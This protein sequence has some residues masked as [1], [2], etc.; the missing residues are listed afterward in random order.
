MVPDVCCE[1]EREKRGFEGDDSCGRPSL[2]VIVEV[3]V[4]GPWCDMSSVSG[5]SAVCSSV[6]MVEADQRDRETLY[7]GGSDFGR[8]RDLAG[9]VLRSIP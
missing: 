3:S 4:M 6:E 8:A 2:Y 5:L 7:S 9:C 1:L